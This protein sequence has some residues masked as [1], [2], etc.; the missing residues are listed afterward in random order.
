MAY[1]PTQ[2]V[3]GK[4][5]AL[6]A[7]NLNK[8][9]AGI[10]NND[11]EINSINADLG[12]LKSE[13]SDVENIIFTSSYPSVKVSDIPQIEKY[14]GY[15]ANAK[16]DGIEVLV[17][18]NYDSYVIVADH[19]C[20]VYV[21]ETI[22]ASEYY[23]I[24]IGK[25]YTGKDVYSNG[26][27]KL[28]SSD[29][30]RYRNSE[31]NLPTESNKLSVNTGDVIAFTFLKGKSFTLD[32]YVEVKT[33][34][35]SNSAGYAT[36]TESSLVVTVGKLRV[37]I[38]KY[39][40]PN[41]RAVNLWRANDAYIKASNGE[42]TRLWYNSDSDG[43]VKIKDEDDFIGG[44]HGDETQTAFRLFIDG[45][46]YSEVSAF[47][48]LDFN[49]LVI[50]CESEI[51]HCNTSGTPDVMAFKRNKIITFNKDGYSVSNYWV[52]Q[53]DLTIT[54]AYMGMLSIERYT[55]NN[56]TD[57]LINGYHTNNDFAFVD[58]DTGTSA[59]KDITEVVFNTIHGD[60]GIKISDIKTIDNYSYYGNITNYNSDYDKRLKVY[61]ANID[62]NSGKSISAGTVIKANAI[63]F[64]R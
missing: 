63:T 43:V 10:Q 49:E 21:D 41:I 33:P 64:I 9:E 7:E 5:P 19:N 62:S 2:W 47:T 30:V 51:Y 59:N 50:Y 34:K 6:N 27:F 56:Y 17:S 39:N 60:V 35:I 16:T 54:K 26:G 29:S 20:D 14:E 40:D 58:A 24:T 12:E 25:N 13:L 8:L 55:D 42:F 44:Y 1:T 61:L 15:S 48:D 32:G 31:S 45:V 23:A 36:K 53:E 46:E 4:P 52:A 22:P 57:Y 28:L 11:A 38:N 37:A 3:N 18:T